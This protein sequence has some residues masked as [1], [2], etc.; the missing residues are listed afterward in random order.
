ML[1]Y[2]KTV[3]FVECRQFELVSVDFACASNRLACQENSLACHCGT[4][5]RGCRSLH[6]STITAA[7]TMRSNF[8]MAELLRP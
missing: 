7:M 6:L 8:A 5:A 3:D 4:R 2:F 1:D